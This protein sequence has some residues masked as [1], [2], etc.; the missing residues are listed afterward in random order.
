MGYIICF[1]V[2]C[3]VGMIATAAVVALSEVIA[4]QV[5]DEE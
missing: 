1:A 5:G 2:G 3:L 4:C